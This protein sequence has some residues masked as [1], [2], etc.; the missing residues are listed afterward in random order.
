[1][2]ASTLLTGFPTRYW[3]QLEDGRIQCDVC[4]RYCK[5]HEGQNGLCFVRA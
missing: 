1:M 3:H 2:S 5:L 4:P